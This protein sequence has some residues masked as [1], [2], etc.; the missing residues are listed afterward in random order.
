MKLPLRLEMTTTRADFLRL[1]PAAVNHVAFSEEGEAFVYREGARGWR[2]GL[3]RLPQLRIG[4]LQLDR[5]QV[6]FVFTGYSEAEID[7][8]MARFEMYFRRGGG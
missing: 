3:Q 5:H 8:F 2:I 7:A 4:L 6:D 1:L